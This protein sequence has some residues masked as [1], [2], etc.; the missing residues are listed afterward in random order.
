MSALNEEEI[1][2]RL[3][4]HHDWTV[5]DGA[6]HREFKFE[7]FPAAMAFM[8]QASRQ[9]DAMNH[10]PE[11]SNV[12]NVVDVRLTSHDEGGITDRDFTLAGIFDEL[13]SPTA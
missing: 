8:V 13:A 1:N 7:G 5:E 6:L 2:E 9:I 10:H 3:E 12:Y 11:W 4:K